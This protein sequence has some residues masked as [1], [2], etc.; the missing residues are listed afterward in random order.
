M[1]VGTDNIVI[2]NLDDLI[3][4][5]WYKPKVNKSVPPGFTLAENLLNNKGGILFAKGT[6]I[7]ANK[8]ERL[9]KLKENNK[10]WKFEF[11]LERS[12]KLINTLN[13]RLFADFNRFLVSKKSK[14]EFKRFMEK[15]G[16]MLENY[17]KEILNND[18]IV[19]KLYSIRFKEEKCNPDSRTPYY[20]HLL[21]TALI[22]MGMINQA[23]SKFAKKFASEDIVK[24]A[25]VGIFHGIGGISLVDT[26]CEKAPEE[27]KI[28]YTEGNKNSSGMASHLGL[29]HD[30]VGSIKHCNDF[31]QGNKEFMEKEEKIS[32]YANMAIVAS[33]FNAK[34]S[35]LFGDPSP[36]KN[37][38]DQLYVMATN[39]ELKKIYVDMLATGLKFGYLFDFYYEIEKLNKACPYGKHGRP[40]PMTGF[41]S[42]VIYV[43]KGNVTTCKHYVS[44]SKAVTIFKKV[45][46]LN[47]GTYGRCEW[48]SNGLIKFY[49]KFYE[50]I[51]E[52]TISRSIS[53]DGQ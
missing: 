6:E 47:E 29:G 9:I 2:E 21:N 13:E 35:G 20:N 44:S 51:K 10:S 19:L 22:V 5:T 4:F 11:H 12:E 17:R 34:I 38:V 32:E 46:E 15:V 3:S 1:I 14:Q 49:D 26:F 36:A 48:L 40:Y 53:N 42:P 33:N 16:N 37:V 39:N 27:Q 7:D 50:Q 8:V 24:G 31:E 18:E 45:G 43:C 28:R 25:Q 23:I 30:V 41:K 52:E